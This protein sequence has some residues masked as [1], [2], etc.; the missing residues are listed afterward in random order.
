MNEKTTLP[1]ES[2]FWDKPKDTLKINEFRLKKFLMS[3]G[4]GQFQM[5]DN[6]TSKSVVF[7]N[8]FG[9]LKIHNEESIKSWLLGYLETTP[10]KEFES[11]KFAN[12]QIS[13]NSDRSIKWD[14]LARVQSYDK[15]RLKNNVLVTL[16]KNSEVGYADTEMLCMFDDTRK[17]AHI[18]FKNGIVKVTADSYEIIPY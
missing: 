3:H 10:E 8:H 7:Q 17:S 15:G 9:I 12:K 11:G 16:P 13:G 1:K 18:R 5:G 14:V 4:F 6:R 2:H